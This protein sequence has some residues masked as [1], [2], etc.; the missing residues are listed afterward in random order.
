MLGGVL[1]EEFKSCVPER[2]V[3]YLNEQKVSTLRQAAILA[4]EFALTHKSAFFRHE[5]STHLETAPRSSDTRVPRAGP[6]FSSPKTD[7]QCFFCQKTDH[8]VADCNAWKRRQQTAPSK[9]KG[10]GLVKTVASCSPPPGQ[11]GPDECFRPF[12][13]P[14]FV[15]LTG[16]AD[17]RRPFTVLRDTGGSQSFILSAVLPL[18]AESACD[19]STVVRGIGMGFVPAPLHRIH[20][21]SNL[22]TGFFRV[23][24]RPSFPIDGVDFIMGND[25]AGGKVYPSP[26]VV[27]TPI[28]ESR[29]DDL[30]QCH[31]D[32]FAVRVLTR[33]QARKQAQDVDLSDSVFASALSEDRLPPVGETESSAASLEKYGSGAGPVA[34]H[35]LALTREALIS[36]QSGDPSLRK[37]FAAV[38]D[39]SKCTE[40]QSF[41]VDNGVLMRRWTSPLGESNSVG[42]GGPVC[43]IVVPVAYRR[44]VLEG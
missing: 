42:G 8:L 31:P 22:K 7:R 20:V 10:V 13:L 33:A 39:L 37:C 38:E 29:H 11:A 36:S 16:E 25:I 2:T 6:A 35:G 18:S 12:I 4:D 40:K 15:S 21:Q 28:A 5:S 43:Q 26:E 34:D 9:P 19:V 41:S 17:D 44:H 30:F 23:A 3:V 27:D 14:A 24:V 32:L 1:L